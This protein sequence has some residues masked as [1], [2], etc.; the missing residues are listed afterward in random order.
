MTKLIVRT[1]FL[2]LALMSTTNS[3]RTFAEQ[4]AALTPAQP[5]ISSPLNCCV[6]DPTCIPDQPCRFGDTL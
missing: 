1:S 5:T 3:S 4:K 2:L 6:P